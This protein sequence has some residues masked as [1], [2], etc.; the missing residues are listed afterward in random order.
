MTPEEKLKIIETWSH[1]F[2][3]VEREHVTGVTGRLT[4]GTQ[5]ESSGKYS[6]AGHY[7]MTCDTKKE[8]IDAAF[9]ALKEHIWW[10]VQCV[11]KDVWL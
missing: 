2:E 6:M 9:R 3:F 5:M 4:T 7:E 10:K 1:K 8:V 11:N